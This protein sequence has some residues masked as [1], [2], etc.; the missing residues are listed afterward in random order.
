LPHQQEKKEE[1]HNNR[2][3]EG[4]KIVDSKTF[5]VLK[6]SRTKFCKHFGPECLNLLWGKSHGRFFFVATTHGNRYYGKNEQDREK[7]FFHSDDFVFVLNAKIFFGNSN[8]FATMIR[9]N[10]LYSFSLKFSPPFEIN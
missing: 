4:G 2:F 5:R 9:L 1:A 8:L 3:G 10:N 6:F 7:V